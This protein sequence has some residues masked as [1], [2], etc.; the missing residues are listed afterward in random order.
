M[1]QAIIEGWVGCNQYFQK[2]D[3]VQPSLSYS[4]PQKLSKLVNDPVQHVSDL[5]EIE[6]IKAY[7]VIVIAVRPGTV[8]EICADLSGRISEKTNVI[9]IAAGVPHAVLFKD[10]GVAAD[11]VFRVMPNLPVAINKGLLGVFTTGNSDLMDALFA[12]LGRVINLPE[13]SQMHGFIALAGSGPAYVYMFAQLMAD[14]ATEMG[15]DK[16]TAQNVAIA[17]VSGA[18]QK[19]EYSC[20]QDNAL[21]PKDCADKVAVKGGTTEAALSEFLKDGLW[22]DLTRHALEAAAKKSQFLE[23]AISGEA[24]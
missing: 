14:V 22:K 2:L 10:L 17:M 3:I 1:M 20:T 19:L 16:D 13:E 4:L 11:K 12:G 6:D 24:D 7:D 5:A 18:G 23:A 21:T 8:K 15:M 9:S